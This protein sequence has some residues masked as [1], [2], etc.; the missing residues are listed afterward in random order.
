MVVAYH[1][2][3]KSYTGTLCPILQPQLN[4]HSPNIYINWVIEAFRSSAGAEYIYQRLYTQSEE[5]TTH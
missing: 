3:F 2:A 4:F 1:T 5:V